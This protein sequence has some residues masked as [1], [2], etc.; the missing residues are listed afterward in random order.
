MRGSV[1][2][3]RFG[4]MPR[5]LINFLLKEERVKRNLKNPFPAITATRFL[6]IFDLIRERILKPFYRSMP[7]SFKVWYDKVRYHV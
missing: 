6:Y 1:T 5:P 7:L 3:T 2:K 4:F